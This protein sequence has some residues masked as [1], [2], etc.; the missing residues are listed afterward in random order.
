MTLLEKF[1][2]KFEKPLDNLPQVCYNKSTKGQGRRGQRKPI[3]LSPTPE[4]K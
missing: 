4:K 2:K 3:I 1:S